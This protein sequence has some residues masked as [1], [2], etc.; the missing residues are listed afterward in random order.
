VPNAIS[1]TLAI[2]TA[3]KFAAQGIVGGWFTGA[4]P[5]DTPGPFLVWTGAIDAASGTVPFK[6]RGLVTADE[7]A[8][9]ADAS[10][11]KTGI[12]IAY[13][14]YGQLRTLLDGKPLVL[15]TDAS[16]TPLRSVRPT[17]TMTALLDDPD[18]PGRGHVAARL[19]VDTWS[20]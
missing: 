7:F 14:I 10:D 16:G 9:Y 11:V 13:G 17:L 18:V 2:R 19:D 6:R 12:E 3:M 15:G 1:P 4:A 5:A 20:A 8:I